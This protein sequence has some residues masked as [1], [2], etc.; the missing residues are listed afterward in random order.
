[1]DIRL[2]KVVVFKVN[3]PTVA[4]TLGGVASYSTLVE[5]RGRLRKQGGNRNL[6]G[7]EFSI[8]GS[9][10]LIVRYTDT[11]Y[12]AIKPDMKMEIEGVLYS[13]VSWE[14]LDEKRFYIKFI[15]NR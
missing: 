14:K 2:N 9:Y 11:I 15:I 13:I 8:D 7:G 5:T 12:N 10:E 6:T 1:M 3:T 4:A